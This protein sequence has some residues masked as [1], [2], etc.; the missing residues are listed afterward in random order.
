MAEELKIY[1]LNVGQ[2]DT[3]FIELPDKKI[4][5]V[6]F[7]HDPNG[8]HL[9][10]FL[11][12]F[13]KN[14][15]NKIDYLIIT[16]PDGDHVKGLDELEKNKLDYG[17][18]FDSTLRKKKEK[19]QEYPEYDAYIDFL[20]KAEG[21]GKVKYIK[22]DTACHSDLKF[23]W[24]GVKFF[25]PD[26]DYRK[27]ELD[28]GAINRKSVIVQIDFHGTTTL[29]TADTDQYTYKEDLKNWSAFKFSMLESKILQASHHGSRSFFKDKEEDEPYKEAID[30][31]KPEKVFISVGKDNEHD[32]PHKDALDIYKEK[33]REVY[34]TDK[35]GTVIVTLRYLNK[36]VELDIDPDNTIDAD[37]PWK[38]ENNDDNDNKSS[39]S[40]FVK[41]STGSAIL[42]GNPKG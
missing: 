9:I 26:K 33:K 6:D 38:D 29:F 21:K 17:L 34:R 18:L 41:S 32:L 7:H 27:E 22:R 23:D 28:N 8:I 42:G 36:K 25:M 4:M 39:G 37:Y 11:K 40:I 31:I 30:A 13:T 1:F 15:K 14:N 19:G 3:T 12:D 10:N 2:G 20:K 16:H 24:G 35:D 5:M